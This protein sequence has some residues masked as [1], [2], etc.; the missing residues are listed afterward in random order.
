M[1]G[2]V[3]VAKDSGLD[4][5]TLTP[6]QNYFL[7][8]IKLGEN[9]KKITAGVLATQQKQIRLGRKVD[10]TMVAGIALKGQ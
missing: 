4:G 7:L 10:D 1:R 2:I 9:N 5:L 6:E 3:A 8:Q